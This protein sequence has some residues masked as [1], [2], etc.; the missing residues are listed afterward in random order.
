[1][2]REIY[3]KWGFGMASPKPET[4]ASRQRAAERLMAF[5]DVDT[6]DDGLLDALSE[7][8]GLFSRIARQDQWDWFSISRALV[9]KI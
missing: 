7:M 8:K 6:R 1:M 4:Q 9:D 2:S 3:Q 5:L